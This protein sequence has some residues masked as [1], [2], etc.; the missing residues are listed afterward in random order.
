MTNPAKIIWILILVLGFFGI[1]MVKLEVQALKIEVA[2]TE[3]QLK[4]EKRNLH[5]LDTEWAFLTRPDRLKQLADK[6][7][8][9]KPMRGQQIVEFAS[10]PY[11]KTLAPVQ[12]ASGDK[13]AAITLVGGIEQPTDIGDE[14]V[15]EE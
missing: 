3:K 2:A 12:Q 13:K 4:E 14:S 6:Y 15:N 8:A 1:Y 5:V 9:V 10:I 11:S 7:L